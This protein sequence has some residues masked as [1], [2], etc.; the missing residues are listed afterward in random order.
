[1]AKRTH[2]HWGAAR[3]CTS[4]PAWHLTFCALSALLA[5]H[6]RASARSP[7]RPGPELAPLPTPRCHLSSPTGAPGEQGARPRERAAHPGGQGCQAP[8]GPETG[9][10][11]RRNVLESDGFPC[12]LKGGTGRIQRRPLRPQRSLRHCAWSRTGSGNQLTQGPRRALRH[13][14][15]D[16]AGRVSDGETGDPSVCVSGC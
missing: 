12:F 5:L 1:M 14:T 6:T 13:F 11:G 2:T 7:P 16:A 15:T 3:G 9:K 10:P 8:T 4:L